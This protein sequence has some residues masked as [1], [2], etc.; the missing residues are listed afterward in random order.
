MRA[1]AGADA[2]ADSGGDA[3]AAPRFTLETEFEQIDAQAWDALAG[4][5]PFQRHAFLHA[6]QK[7]GCTTQQTGW[8]P[9][10][11]LMH[12]AGELTGAMAL[13]LKSHSRGEYVFDHAWADAF[14]RHGLSYY[15]KLL[16]ASPFTPVAG[17]RLLATSPERRQQLAVAAIEVAKQLQVSSLH[18][19]FPT[20][21]EA[22]AL[23]H[24]GYLVREGVQFHWHNDHYP[25]LEA[26]LARMTHDKRKKIRQD[27]KR[28]ERAGVHFEIRRGAEVTE[29]DLDFFYACY[30]NTYL[31]HGSAPY[32]NRAF[33]GDLHRDQ[34]AGFVLVLAY[35]AGEPLACALNILGDDVL[36]GRYWG[37]MD[38]V[39]GL[40]FETC[41]LQAI[42]WCITQGVTRFEGGAQGE[43]K[44]ARGLV[45]VPTCSAHWISDPRFYDAIDDYLQRETQWIDEYRDD[46]AQHVPFKQG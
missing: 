21:D 1:D 44:M 25:H 43:H 19:L 15:P 42:E 24:A 33:F 5:F 4:P 30:A 17:P 26:F 9:C 28:V 39:P 10:A 7:R 45:P 2:D 18:I 22:R 14:E 16:A 20:P 38:F 6:M 40:H 3:G 34:E 37:T 41:Y 32:L 36:Y 8:R 46:L 35:R 13:Y 29:D 11:L 31:Q 12:E 27:R 23:R